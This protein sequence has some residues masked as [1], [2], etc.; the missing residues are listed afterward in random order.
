M[1]FIM[2]QSLDKNWID[3]KTFIPDAGEKTSFEF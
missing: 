3:N 2:R 1:S